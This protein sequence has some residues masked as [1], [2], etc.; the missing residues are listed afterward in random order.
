MNSREKLVKFLTEL[1]RII[2]GITFVFSGFVK[3]VDPLGFTYKIQDYLVSF[4]LPGLFHLALP[5]AVALVVLEFLLGVFL[6]L[7]IYRKTTVRLT[8]VFMAFFIPLTLWIALKNPVKD[9][10]CFGDALIISNWET[11][12]KNIVLGVCAV[13]L[14]RYSP[15]ITSLFSVGTAWKAGVFTAVFGLAFSIYNVVK[16]PVFDFRPYHIGANITENMYIDPAK[17]DV[18]ENVFI[19]SKNGVEQEFTE[20]NYPWNDST[21]TFVEMKTKLI[22]E[23]ERPRIEDFQISALVYDSLLQGFVAG[24]DIT[25]QLLSDTGYQFLMVSHSLEEMN[26]SHLDDFRK[27][28]GFAQKNGYDFYCLTSST[29]DFIDAWNARNSVGFRFAHT[30]E[31]V[32]KTMIRSNPGLLLL[33]GGTVINK[34]DDSEVPDF[35]SERGKSLLKDIGWKMNFWGKLI[36]ILLIFIVPLLLIKLEEFKEKRSEFLAKNKGYNKEI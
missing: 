15:R 16:L 3:A 10:G 6:L 13:I 25:Q 12:Y 30:D 14:L 31:R 33:S 27:V 21:W 26:K 24:D 35:E 1:S 32:L 20:E 5:A 34:W 8:A 18:V 23:G 4:N 9:C 36:V 29:V 2:L 17:A 19:Y 28:A 11:F 22:Q 7:G